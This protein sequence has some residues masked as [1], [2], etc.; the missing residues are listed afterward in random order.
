VFCS[1]SPRHFSR[2]D[3]RYPVSVLAFSSPLIFLDGPTTTPPSCFQFITHQQS[4]VGAEI[5]QTV[6]GYSR[7]TVCTAGLFSTATR[8]AVGPSK[9]P[10]RHVP[11]A[12]K[13]TTHIHLLPRL[14]MVTLSLH[15]PLR[16]QAVVLT[17]LRACGALLFLAILNASKLTSFIIKV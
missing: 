9:S 11:P 13:L 14:R 5:A 1:R 4:C 2:P 17:Y 12:V 10:V 8:S 7:P 3:V 15:S 6:R 16:L